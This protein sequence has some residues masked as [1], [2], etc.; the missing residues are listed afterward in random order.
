M[1][2]NYG[3]TL[4][5]RGNEARR[6]RALRTKFLGIASAPIVAAGG[7]VALA[8][9]VGSAIDD[10]PT[11]ALTEAG[12]TV[13]GTALVLGGMYV[14]KWRSYV[15]KTAEELGRL[16]QIIRSHDRQLVNYT[17]RRRLPL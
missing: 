17:Y 2:L 12:I 1:D 8:Q 11:R 6:R 4:E 14:S 7:L 3:E 13:V 9:G 5:A 16:N 10:Y 15:R